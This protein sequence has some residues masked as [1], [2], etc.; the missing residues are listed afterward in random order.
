MR[1]L[2]LACLLVGA[3]FAAELEGEARKFVQDGVFSC[4]ST[5]IKFQ[6]S[7]LNAKQLQIQYQEATPGITWQLMFAEEL[8]HVAVVTYTK[9][10]AEYPKTDQVLER[11]AS[12][13]KIEA[14][15]DGGYLEW[16]GFLSND[17]GKIL[18]CIVRYPR[19]G[20]T[21]SVRNK[22][23]G[24]M[25]SIRLD[26]YELRHYIVREGFML[27]FK[28]FMPQLLPQ[29]SF[30]EDKLVDSWADALARFVCGCSLIG[31]EDNYRQQIKAFT[32][33]DSYF[34]FVFSDPSQG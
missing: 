8:G 31:K 24:S 19:A 7:D 17:E 5:G 14:M 23:L 10:R 18:Q 21:V 11:T 9:I 13:M 12:N 16:C 33:P 28:L 4:P 29:G 1:T 22:W 2:L 25:E 32:R 34:R 6:I 3:V 27:E 30:N 26:V 15:R 20:Q